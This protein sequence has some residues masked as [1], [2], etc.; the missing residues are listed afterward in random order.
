[1]ER[2]VSRRTRNYWIWVF[3]ILAIGVLVAAWYYTRP[4]PATN[5]NQNSNQSA[6]INSNVKTEV[7]SQENANS[8]DI[9]TIS[10]Q[11]SGTVSQNYNNSEYGFSLTYSAGWKRASSVTG[12]GKDKIYSLVLSDPA[13]PTSTVTI[14]VMDDSLEGQVKNSI[15]VTSEKNI[16]VNGLSAQKLTG[17][18]AKDG[19]P[20]TIVLLNKGASLFSLRGNGQDYENIVNS[21]EL[22]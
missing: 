14:S 20:V 3:G 7:N 13:N 4:D 1:M 11:N 6:A 16:T 17:G 22:K 12:S 21:F 15:S 5:A 19:S 8:S 9:N 10:N 2:G 18:S